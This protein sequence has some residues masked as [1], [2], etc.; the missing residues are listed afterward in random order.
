MEG[1]RPTVRRSQQPL[2]KGVASAISGIDGVD[3]EGYRDYR[4][5]CTL[6]A[7][8]WFPEFEMGVVTE[9]D[10]TEAYRPLTILQWT[11]RSLLVLLATSSVAIFL[12]TVRVARLQREA[13]KTAIELN[14][15]LKLVVLGHPGLGAIRKLP[16][17]LGACGCSAIGTCARFWLLC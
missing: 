3:I 11:F 7:W 9:L 15:D 14:A 13:Q 5:V 12:F 8:K 17:V 16:V 4:G 6:G 1:Y 10:R 2:T